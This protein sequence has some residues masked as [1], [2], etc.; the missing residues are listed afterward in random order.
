MRRG[1]VDIITIGSLTITMV[2]HHRYLQIPVQLEKIL[3]LRCSWRRG[4]EIDGLQ[5]R[6]GDGGSEISKGRVVVTVGG[7]KRIL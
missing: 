2:S 4:V 7:A 6:V 5:E 3:S 1:V